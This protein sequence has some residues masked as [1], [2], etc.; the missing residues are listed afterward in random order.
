M[1]VYVFTAECPEQGR[2][3]IAVTD[4]EPTDEQMWDMLEA[5]LRERIQ[6]DNPDAPD[7]YLPYLDQYAASEFIIHEQE[8]QLIT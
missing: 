1:K 8:V 5:Y 3:V 6:V 7:A 4:V 2:D